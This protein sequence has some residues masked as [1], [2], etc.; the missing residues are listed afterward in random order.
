MRSKAGDLSDGALQDVSYLARSRNRVQILGGLAGNPTTPRELAELTGASRS[1]LQRILSELE[2]RE[3]ATRTPE[4]N[5]VA[6]PTGAHVLNEFVP[7]VESMEAMTEL[8]E[9]V[10]S[11]PTDSF[12]LGM[13]HFKDATVVRPAANDPNAPGTYFTTAIRET[14]ELSCVVDLAAPLALEETMRERVVDGALQSEH[15][16]TERLFQ[17][18]CRS[19]ERAQ[20]WKELAQSGADVYLYDGQIQCNVFILDETVLLGETPPEGEGCVLIETENEPVLEWT[21]E[22]VREHRATADRLTG[23]EFT[24]E[25]ASSAT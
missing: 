5:Y 11:L 23:E 18:N 8:G 16:L 19:R 25:Q 17:Y 12:S 22:F 20:T 21:R 14:A 24:D 3:W 7:F 6:T 10:A 1:T 9:A 2:A 13:Q 15:V 4:G